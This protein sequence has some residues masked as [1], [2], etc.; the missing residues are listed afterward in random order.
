MI[1]ST[2]SLKEPGLQTISVVDAL[3]GRLRQEIFSG[4]IPAGDRIKEAPLAQKLGVSRHTLRA[5]LSRL[6]NVGLLQYR[7]NRGWSVPVFGKEEYSDI[8]ILRESLESS[9]Y[10]IILAKQTKPGAHVEATL[11]DLLSKTA[12]DSWCERLDADCNLHQSLVDLAGSSRLS[13]AFSDMMDE[14]RLCRLQSIS[15]LEQLSLEE[16][17]KKHT[18]LV[19]GLAAADIDAIA[20][21]TSGHFTTNPWNEPR[22]GTADS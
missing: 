15:W 3:E 13:K 16:W 11:Q 5:A 4:S 7:E 10:R 2:S 14:F 17:K 22:I 18:E 12:E 8:L 1:S 21:A 19:E 9:A 20:K 6:E